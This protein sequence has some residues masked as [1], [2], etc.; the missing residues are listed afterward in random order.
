MRTLDLHFPGLPFPVA[1]LNRASV[2]GGA[3]A[4]IGATLTR[5]SHLR[6]RIGDIRSGVRNISYNVALRGV[7]H[8]RAR[9]RRARIHRGR[10]RSSTRA[11]HESPDEDDA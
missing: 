5:T 4:L 11:P 6:R 1:D 10:R 7:G 9:V 8:I 2:A 3:S